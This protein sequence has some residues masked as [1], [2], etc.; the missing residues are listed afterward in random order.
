LPSDTAETLDARILAEEHRVYPA[1][2]QLVLAGGWRL[3]GR[4]FVGDSKQLG[5]PS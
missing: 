5:R 3:E 4:R 1:A 2:I